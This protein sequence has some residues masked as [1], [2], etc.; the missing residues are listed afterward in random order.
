MKLLT[1]FKTEI[2][3]LDKT[4]SKGITSVHVRASKN[5]QG[6]PGFQVYE[7]PYIVRI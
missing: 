2:N 3:V 4:S 7:P 1:L 5:T 6:I